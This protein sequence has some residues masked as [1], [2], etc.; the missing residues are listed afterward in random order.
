MYISSSFGNSVKDGRFMPNDPASFPAK[1][2]PVS[3]YA[4]FTT[5]ALLVE[6]IKV[7]Q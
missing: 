1:R 5:T 6:C 4:L 2:F 3:K 7:K